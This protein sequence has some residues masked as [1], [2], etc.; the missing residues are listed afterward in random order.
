MVRAP[1]A[2]TARRRRVAA[3]AVVGVAAL[4]LSGC[5]LATSNPAPPGV[6]MM[7]GGNGTGMM[8]GRTAVSGTGGSSMMNGRLTCT[9]PTSL[10]GSQVTVALVDMGMMSGTTDPAPL[11]IP[12]R[13]RTS[14][15]SVPAGQ[16]SFVAENLGRRTHELVV[17]PL[18]AGQSPGTR[19]PA[20]DGKVL[21]TGS[22]GEA[23]NPCGAGSADGLTAGTS[24]W[25]T[26]TLTPGRYEI[27]CNEANH[28]ADGMW[29]ELD[30]S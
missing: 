2:P 11:G 9:A 7:G 14:T 5:G 13:L 8:G 18:A 19:T 10:P 15:N 20:A 1:L 3:L 21:E 22:L 16:V 24:G 28:Y 30:V 12:M 29:A 25:V 17:L 6:A 26:L 27:V 4:G 23:S